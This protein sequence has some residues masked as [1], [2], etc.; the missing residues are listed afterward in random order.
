[1]AT[2]GGGKTVSLQEEIMWKIA[3]NSPKVTSLYIDPQVLGN[4]AW[5]VGGTVLDL[6]PKGNAVINPMDRYVL[7][8]PA[9]VIPGSG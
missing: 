4:L 3:H 7:K 2:T 1:L 5:L 6:G 8:R 9:G